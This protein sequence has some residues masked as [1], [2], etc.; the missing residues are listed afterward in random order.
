MALTTLPWIWQDSLLQESRMIKIKT[1]AIDHSLYSKSYR[2]KKWTFEG[3][4]WNEVIMDKN[5][6]L[7][8]YWS[9]IMCWHYAKWGVT[10]ITKCNG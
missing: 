8:E 7:H 6:V 10:N 1:S 5:E 3:A 4:N 2:W 9:Q